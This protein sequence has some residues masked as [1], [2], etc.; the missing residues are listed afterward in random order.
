MS[1]GGKSFIA[2]SS[3]AKKGTVYKIKASL[4]PGAVVTTGKNDVDYVVTECGAVKLRGKTAGERAK[5]LI[6]IA[7]PDF[8]AELTREAKKMHLIA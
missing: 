4:T 5:I 2:F 7:H 8:R 6:S 1:K 3:T